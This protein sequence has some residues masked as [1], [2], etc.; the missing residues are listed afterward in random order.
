MDLVIDAT[1]NYRVNH[2]LADMS[3]VEGKAYVWLS[4][5]PGAAGGVVGRVNPTETQGCWHC[6]QHAMSAGEIRYPADN[7]ALDIQPR[8]CTHPTFVAAGI[9]SDEV[10]ILASRLAVA[11]LLAQDDGEGQTSDF[12]WD[13]AVGDFFSANRRIESRWT[14]YSLNR[15]PDC[16]ACA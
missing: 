2:L 1:A 13:V 7:G 4:T 6:F 12:E 5:T 10:S 14:T 9:D 15:H 3:G 16:S 8:G 11:T